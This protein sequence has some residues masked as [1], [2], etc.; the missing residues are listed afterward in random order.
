MHQSSIEIGH[1]MLHPAPEPG[2]FS[3]RPLK[4]NQHFRPECCMHPLFLRNKSRRALF[5]LSSTAISPTQASLSSVLQAAHLAHQT[6]RVYHRSSS[7][8]VQLTR[9]EWLVAPTRG[10]FTPACRRD[11]ARPVC[12]PSCTW[13][14]S[15]GSQSSGAICRV[16]SQGRRACYRRAWRQLDDN[17]SL[18]QNRTNEN[19]TN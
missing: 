14:P 19:R 10:Q 8:G 13:F 15:R 9:K 4:V 12:S 3:A 6:E 17:I 11:L 16:H 1:T 18:A 7:P 2:S 5:C